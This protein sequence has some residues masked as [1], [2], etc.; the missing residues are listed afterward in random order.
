MCPTEPPQNKQ[1]EDLLNLKQVLQYFLVAANFVGN[2]FLT[3]FLS[4]NTRL[5]VF[6]MINI[7]YIRYHGGKSSNQ[8]LMQ[9]AFLSTAVSTVPHFLH[10]G[11]G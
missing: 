7:I 3:I 6:F 8:I 2:I 4:E 10:P 1:N 9:R 5:S 11:L